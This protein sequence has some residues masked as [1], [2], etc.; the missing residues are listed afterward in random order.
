MVSRGVT[1]PQHILYVF[2]RQSRN[3]SSGHRSPTHD[4]LPGSRVPFHVFNPI[5]APGSG[6]TCR[7]RAGELIIYHTFF[8][9]RI[10]STCP[11]HWKEQDAGRQIKGTGERGSSRVTSLTYPPFLSQPTI[12]AQ[13]N[14]SVQ[15]HTNEN[16]KR[17]RRISLM[18]PTH[19]PHD[20]RGRQKGRNIKGERDR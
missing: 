1:K 3:F 19:E 18:N 16:K 10:G 7:R 13:Q 9:S 6:S 17:T 14:G 20:I 2:F 4:G 8:S 11:F 5:Q 15:Y 12:A